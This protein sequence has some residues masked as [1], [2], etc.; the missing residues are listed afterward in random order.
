MITVRFPRADSRP[1]VWDCG[2]P[3]SARLEIALVHQVSIPLSLSLS[4]GIRNTLWRGTSWTVKNLLELK[5]GPPRRH[6]P[7][8]ARLQLGGSAARVCDCVHAAQLERPQSVGRDRGRRVQRE[9]RAPQRRRLQPARLRRYGD[10]RPARAG[11]HQEQPGLRHQWNELGRRRPVRANGRR[12][13]R[14][15]LRSRHGDPH[16]QHR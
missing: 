8:P 4:S 6:Q 15:H 16:R 2:V 3:V 5:T 1:H 10:Q 14:H 11:A 12:A 9:R 13:A 7:Q